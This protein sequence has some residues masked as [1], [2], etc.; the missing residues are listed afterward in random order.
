PPQPAARTAK[1]AVSAITAPTVPA[2]RDLRCTVLVPPVSDRPGL[3][4]MWVVLSDGGCVPLLVPQR[5]LSPDFC[6]PKRKLVRGIS[7]SGS[8]GAPKR[9]GDE[10]L[11]HRRRELL[12]GAAPG[13]QAA[14]RITARP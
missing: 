3:T 7:P 1:A 12:V 14:Q 13:S 11:D 6:H 9:R 10:A 8:S 5:G 4:Y 2:R